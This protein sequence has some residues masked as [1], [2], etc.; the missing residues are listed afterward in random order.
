MSILF[1]YLRTYLYKLCPHRES[2]PGPLVLWLR[3]GLT[4]PVYGSFSLTGL[5]KKVNQLDSGGPPWCAHHPPQGAP[6]LP[7][8]SA[9]P[10][11]NTVW[12]KLHY[13]DPPR[14]PTDA[15]IILLPK[16][17]RPSILYDADILL[18]VK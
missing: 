1:F 15:N 11:H 12:K 3:L 17:K 4:R 13:N 7:P 18:L 6:G 16:I 14:S 10:P 9:E 8:G 2:N 5:P